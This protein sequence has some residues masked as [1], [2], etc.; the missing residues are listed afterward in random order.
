MIVYHEDKSR[1]GGTV[2]TV[3]CPFCA[4]SI[5]GNLPHHLRTVCDATQRDRGRS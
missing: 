1:G 3:S 2:R 5:D 4:E